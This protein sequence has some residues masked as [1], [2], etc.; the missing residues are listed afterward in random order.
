MSRLLC[1]G[2]A[3]TLS[4]FCSVAAVQ[5]QSVRLIGDYRDWS[6]Y[7]ASEGAGALCFV[8]SKPKEVTPLP[9]GFTEAYL[10]LT[11]RPAEG[12]RSEFSLVA[13]F[14]FAPTALPQ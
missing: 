7:S 14:N 11:N 3:A 8:L 1:A 2:I 9:D 4:L 10:Y 6:A 12:L 5:A 13:G